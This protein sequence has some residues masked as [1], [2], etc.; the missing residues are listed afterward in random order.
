M[1]GIYELKKGDFSVKVTNW[2]ATIISVIVPDARGNLDDIVLGYDG[3]G[4]Y[5]NDTTYF[6]ALVGRVANRISGSR[7]TINGTAYRLYPNDGRNSIHGGHRGFSK[8]IWTVKEKVDG[9]YPYITLCL[10]SFDGEQGFP[11]DLDVFV[12][13]RVEANYTLSVSMQA[14]PLN[15]PTPVNLAQH[16]YWNLNGH[17]STTTILSHIIQIFASHITPVDETLIPTGEIAPITN[18]SFDFLQPKPVTRGYDINYVLDSVID[19]KG[20][21]KVSVV[22]DD[23]SGRVMELWSNQAGVQFYT[24]SFLEGVK[25]KNGAVYG[26]YGGLCLETQGFPDAVNHAEFPDQVVRVG[27]VYEHYMVYKFSVK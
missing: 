3:I 2:G 25:G 7:F 17:N 10:H 16:S 22:E 18:T 5:I 26:N 1:V 4:P 14:M 11:G 24:G 23:I 12:T 8:V 27:E 20:M 6:G 21:R 9:E 19:A 13:Y 15:K